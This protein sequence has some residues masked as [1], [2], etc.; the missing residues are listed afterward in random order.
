MAETEFV[1]T[2]ETL[3]ELSRREKNRSELQPLQMSFYDDVARYVRDKQGLLNERECGG[4]PFSTTER[5]KTRQLL[6]NTLKIIRELYERREKK[7]LQMALNK[8]RT[9]SHIVDSSA[10]LDCEKKMFDTL[11]RELDSF[12]KTSFTGILS[13]H[14]SNALAHNTLSGHASS[15][16]VSSGH[17]HLSGTCE[18]DARSEGVPEEE[19]AGAEKERFSVRITASVPKFVGP[20]L[21]VYGPFDADTETELPS[22]IASALIRSGQAQRLAR[23]TQ[24]GYGSASQQSLSHKNNIR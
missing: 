21:E 24:A 23:D 2:Y 18:N 1:I 11:V 13:G 9:A 5:E 20:E 22:D 16:N 4:D 12:R 10:L 15:G 3:Y 6:T 8:S 17:A 19:S 7:I 14:T